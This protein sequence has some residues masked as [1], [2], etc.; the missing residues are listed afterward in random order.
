[1][2]AILMNRTFSSF[3]SKSTPGSTVRLNVVYTAAT[4]VTPTK[5]SLSD[6][7]TTANMASTA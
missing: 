1:M 6:V 4:T 2:T 5:L 7:N 3:I